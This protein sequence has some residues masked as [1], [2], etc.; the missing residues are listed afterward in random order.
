[1]IAFP[2]FDQPM[3]LDFLSRGFY[4]TN[5]ANLLCLLSTC[6]MSPIKNSRIETLWHLTTVRSEKILGDVLYAVGSCNE[7]WIRPNN[8]LSKLTSV[9]HECGKG[10]VS[11]WLNTTNVNIMINISIGIK[12]W[13]SHETSHTSMSEIY[14]FRVHSRNL[15]YLCILY[16][17]QPA[18]REREKFLS[19][20]CFNAEK[21]T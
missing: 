4:S 2:E 19:S 17:H 7:W 15:P 16:S 1:M 8:Y 10:S 3:R 12:R 6:R 18:E 9:F 11:W 5:S 14:E 21:W 13:S 20:S